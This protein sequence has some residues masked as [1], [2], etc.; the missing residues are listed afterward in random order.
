VTAVRFFEDALRIR[1]QSHSDPLLAADT[2][3]GLARALW[4][5]GGDRTKARSLAATALDAYRD[6][7]TT[8]RQNA[9][10]VWLAA[11]RGVSSRSR[12]VR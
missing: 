2:A 6:G 10:A 5:S 9:V 8:D 3:F 12:T 7:R 1:Q 11:H 4:N